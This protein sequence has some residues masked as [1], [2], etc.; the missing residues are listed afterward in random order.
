MSTNAQ[1]ETADQRL[2]PGSGT[3]QADPAW[4]TYFTG[5]LNRV[6]GAPAAIDL[7]EPWGRDGPVYGDPRLA[8]CR[9]GQ[10][11]SRAVVLNAY[12]RPCAI[13]G[14]KIQ[15]VLQAPHV[16]PLPADGEHRLDNGLLP[17]SD[18]HTLIDRDYLAVDPRHR[19]MVSPRLRPPATGLR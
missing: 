16:R 2:R 10:Q 11:A 5:L 12:D 18:V 13:T 4:S 3:Q 19:L 14:S 8:P 7:T 9:L 17:R 1:P 15:P 6:L